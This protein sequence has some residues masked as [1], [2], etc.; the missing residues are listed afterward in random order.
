MSDN[1]QKEVNAAIKIQAVQRGKQVRDEKVKQD[2]MVK[3]HVLFWGKWG[4]DKKAQEFVKELEKICKFE[5]TLEK[6]MGQAS[7]AFEVTIDGT[8]VHSKLNGDDY[9][10]GDKLKQI[11]QIIIQKQ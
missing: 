11:A 9:A 6:W 5:A 4:Y 2:K 8:L 7:G 1:N 10:T 3:L